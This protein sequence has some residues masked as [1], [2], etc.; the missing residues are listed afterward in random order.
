MPSI[1]PMPDYRGN[2]FCGPTA[3]FNLSKNLDPELHLA[4]TDADI[5]Y[6]Y[7]RAENN[8]PY[9]KDRPEEYSVIRGTYPEETEKVL[10]HMGYEWGKVFVPSS[11]PI[12][13]LSDFHENY[14]RK[15]EDGNIL[16]LVI[17]KETNEYH[18]VLLNNEYQACSIHGVCCR[19]EMSEKY[20]P[21]FI[22]ALRITDENKQPP[23]PLYIEVIKKERRKEL[24]FNVS[25]LIN[26]I[27]DYKKY[28][29]ID[30]FITN[31]EDKNNPTS[32]LTDIGPLNKRVLNIGDGYRRLLEEIHGST[33]SPSIYH[34]FI[35]KYEKT[36]FTTV[37]EY[38]DSFN[39]AIKEMNQ[40]FSLLY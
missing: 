34:N 17:V 7:V 37:F 3:I 30:Y 13:S 29:T 10:T 21:K 38:Y 11:K 35:R 24:F 33:K 19:K 32:I 5:L 9:L 31:T 40:T 28:L 12:E 2:C 36:K 20:N 27:K 15:D 25:S 16:Y 14:T 22:S 23:S 18:Y 1:K 26:N 6:R 4:E 39:E 8:T